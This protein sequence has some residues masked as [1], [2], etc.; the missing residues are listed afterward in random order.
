M[1]DAQTMIFSATVPKYIQ[2]IATKYMRNPIML[3]LVGKDAMQMPD[4]ISNEIILCKDFVAKQAFI[5]K[6]IE[7][8][9]DLKILI[10]AETKIEV[11]RYERHRYATFGCLQG[12][13]EQNARLRILQE[14]KR[15]SSDMVLVATDVAARG[16]DI[17]DIDVV[18]QQSVNNVDAF[19]H[20]T[21]RTGRAGKSGR[22]IVLYETER[23]KKNMDF[24]TKIE[25]ALKCNFTY[26]NV[27]LDNTSSEAANAEALAKEEKRLNKLTY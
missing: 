25:K 26:S 20:R 21:G 9:R 19:I 14:Y 3:D 24:F 23:E 1:P 13:L 16:L 11:K 5:K 15:P 22:N 12:D 10:F 17:D 2:E 7:Q 18:I 27:I 6:F 4:T 8:N